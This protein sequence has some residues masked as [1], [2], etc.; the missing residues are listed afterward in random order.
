MS[1]SAFY[2]HSYIYMGWVKYLLFLFSVSYMNLSYI[3][4]N[5]LALRLW[6]IQRHHWHL[7]HIL[8]VVAKNSRISW[9][10]IAGVNA[11]FGKWFRPNSIL[12]FQHLSEDW[13]FHC[14]SGVMS[15]LT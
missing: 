7:L 3:K 1:R 8:H 15:G 5:A 14:V 2:K 9:L 13:L 4:K 11:A 10:A 12:I 6:T